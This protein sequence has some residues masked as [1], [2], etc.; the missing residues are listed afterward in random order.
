[1]HLSTD[2]NLQVVTNLYPILA[3]QEVLTDAQ[4]DYINILFCF[5]KNV[6]QSAR[7]DND[8]LH[9]EPDNR[10]NKLPLANTLHPATKLEDVP[11]LGRLQ[12]IP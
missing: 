10:L 3:W 8:A 5:T 1:M 4:E 12:Q 9:G 2:V 11:F 7:D 6:S